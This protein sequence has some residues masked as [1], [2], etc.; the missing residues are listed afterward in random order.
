MD[1]DKDYLGYNDEPSDEDKLNISGYIDGFAEFIQKCPTPM[2]AAIQGDWGSGKTSALRAIRENLIQDDKQW[3]IDFNTWQYSQFNLGEQLVFSLIGEILKKIEQRVEKYKYEEEGKSV[4]KNNERV[5]TA[6]THAKKLKTLLEPLARVALTM[7]GFGAVNQVVDAVKEGREKAKE[8]SVEEASEDIISSISK[9]RKTLQDLVNTLTKSENDTD[10]LAKRIF[11]FIDDLDRLEPSRAVEVMEA[12]KVFLN[13]E[14]CVFVLAIDFSVVASGVKAKYGSDF[15]ESK[16]RAFF[17]K[18][19]QIPFNLPVG[20]YDIND[21]L[22]DGLNRIGLENENAAD[23]TNFVRFSVGSN[24]RSIKRLINTFG[25]L[26][27]IK[28]TAIKNNGEDEE[29]SSSS[30][31]FFDLFVSLAFQTGYPELFESLMRA[32]STGRSAND[33]FQSVNEILNNTSDGGNTAQLEEWKL[34]SHRVDTAREFIKE[35]LRHFGLSKEGKNNESE[36]Q[37]SEKRLA[38]ALGVASITAVG[39]AELANSVLNRQGSSKLEDLDA[40][41]EKLDQKYSNVYDILRKFDETLLAELGKE[42]KA[43][44][45]GNYWGYASTN[46]DLMIE[47]TRTNRFCEVHYLTKAIRVE[48]GNHLDP[49]KEKQKEKQKKIWE[50]AHDKFTMRAYPSTSNPPLAIKDINSPDLA[51]KAAKFIANVYRRK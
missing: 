35:L 46:P 6:F 12:L 39:T 18:I 16:A 26:T 5:E 20:A 38:D 48:F 17:D 41:L 14:G 25:L 3:V 9:L 50:D 34:P 49:D 51:E 10:K 36:S 19:I 1:T 29:T 22:E 47:R 43:G 27:T 15:E 32:M 8:S 44:D 4:F 40:R 11:I 7:A 33:F 42:I 13:I 2:T 45:T 23:Y 21:L 37:E 30:S 24:P 28:L 31:P